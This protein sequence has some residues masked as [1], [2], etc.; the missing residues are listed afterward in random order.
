MVKTIILFSGKVK[1]LKLVLIKRNNLVYKLDKDDKI[2]LLD[3]IKI[4]EGTYDNNSTR[5]N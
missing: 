4:F 1:D 5:P 3:F 2:T